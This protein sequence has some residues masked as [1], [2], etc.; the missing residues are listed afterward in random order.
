MKKNKRMTLERAAEERAIALLE[1]H[2]TALKEHDAKVICTQ[3]ESR[4]NRR[5][6]RSSNIAQIAVGAGRI[7]AGVGLGI[8]CL[9]FE[10]TG[11]VTSKVTHSI[12]NGV[13]KI[14]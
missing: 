10:E 7:A 8:K 11:S 1:D 12:I 13:T 6:V 9:T 5:A 2:A 4:A 14:F 3:L